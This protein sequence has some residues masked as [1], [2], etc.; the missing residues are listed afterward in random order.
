M[1][2][3]PLSLQRDA[4]TETFSDVQNLINKTCWDFYKR[5]GGDFEEWQAEANLA[6]VQIHSTHK[7]HKGQFSTWLRFCIWKSLLS[8]ARRL[9]KQLPR[10]S[11]DLEED[12]Q[13]LLEALEE[14][15]RPFSSLEL[16]D[17]LQEDT[18][19]LIRLIWNPTKEL[20]EAKMKNGPSPCHMKAVLKKYLHD[21]GW[22]GKRI[23]ESF[24][25]ISRIINE[26]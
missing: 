17:G 11:L 7:K 15:K 3:T 26:N 8:H 12:E 13:N 21:I 20:K 25:E 18:K 19:T 14:E 5:Y 1:K 2:A 10:M 16:M 22:S 24:E 6:F 23:K 4:L 9:Y